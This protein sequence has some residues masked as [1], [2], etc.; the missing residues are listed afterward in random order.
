MVVIQDGV[1]RNEENISPGSIRFCKHFNNYL[2]ELVDKMAMSRVFPS[3][4]T[5]TGSQICSSADPLNVDSSDKKHGHK[6]GHFHRN[7]YN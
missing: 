4:A 2:R 1:G 6:D 3:G 5:Q 7:E